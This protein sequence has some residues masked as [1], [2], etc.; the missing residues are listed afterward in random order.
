MFKIL[1]ICKA[2]NMRCIKTK[3][4]KKRYNETK[5]HNQVNSTIIV[6]YPIKRQRQH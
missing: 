3:E 6:N 5:Q 2:K 4:M 1:R